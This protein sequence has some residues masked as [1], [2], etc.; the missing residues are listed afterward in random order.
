[1]LSMLKS[2]WQVYD[3]SG[4]QIFLPVELMMSGCFSGWDRISSE[5]WLI[6]VQRGSGMVGSDTLGKDIFGV[7]RC[8]EGC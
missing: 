7:D 6:G 1:M 8:G 5:V 3:I 4:R 2:N